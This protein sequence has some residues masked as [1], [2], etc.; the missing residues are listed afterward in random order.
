MI[1]SPKEIQENIFKQV[2][3]SK[4]GAKEYIEIEEKFIK[5]VKDMLKTM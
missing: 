3:A 2:E 5:L 4:E 1:K